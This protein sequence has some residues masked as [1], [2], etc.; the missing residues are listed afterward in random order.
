ML[1]RNLQIHGHAVFRKHVCGRHC[2]TPLTDT[3]FEILSLPPQQKICKLRHLVQTRF[4]RSLN[5]I[6]RFTNLLTYLQITAK[7]LLTAECSG[8]RM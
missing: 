7:L 6:V 1:L 4:D 5:D 2:R 8:E 3:I